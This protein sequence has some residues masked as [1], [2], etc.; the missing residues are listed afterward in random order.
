MS[1]SQKGTQDYDKFVQ[2]FH[3]F[4]RSNEAWDIRD[5]ECGL[6]IDEAKEVIH[7]WAL[8]IADLRPVMVG[9]K[10]PEYHWETVARKKAMLIEEQ[11]QEKESR[12]RSRE[13]VKNLRILLDDVKV[14]MRQWYS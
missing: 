9:E 4:P 12:A 7:Q 5:K 13:H 2:M 3:S 14:S 1:Y 8:Q 6:S 10:R 11:K